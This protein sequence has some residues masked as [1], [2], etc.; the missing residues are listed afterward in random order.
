MLSSK[1]YFCLQEITG[2]NGMYF[3]GNRF[4]Y[5]ELVLSYFTD[6]TPFIPPMVE[7]RVEATSKRL[8]F[9]NR[10]GRLITIVFLCNILLII[11]QTDGL[12]FMIKQLKNVF[13]SFYKKNAYFCY[14][15]I[16]QGEKVVGRFDLR[17]MTSINYKQ[18]WLTDFLKIVLEI[19]QLI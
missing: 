17:T 15:D 11:K 5:L 4:N 19:V 6:L 13:F 12:T 1:V 7:A 8:H 10:I 18:L 9:W 16:L 14:C 3:S 2:L